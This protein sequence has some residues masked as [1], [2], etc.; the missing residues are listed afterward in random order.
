M[1]K[2]R[3]DGK[4]KYAQS[5]VAT[6]NEN[7]PKLVCIHLAEISV[8]ARL[9]KVT[10]ETMKNYLTCIRQIKNETELQ[11]QSKKPK[12][13]KISSHQLTDLGVAGNDAEVMEAWIDK[14]T[15]GM[16]NVMN[17][18]VLTYVTDW[19]ANSDG[20]QLKKVKKETLL[21]AEE[22]LKTVTAYVTSTG[23]EVFRNELTII[24]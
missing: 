23:Y 24:T 17:R 20:T 6:W 15:F 18:A 12:T 5:F 7:L 10:D 2:E 19:E 9:T 1:E 16:I 21:R 11:T 22:Q 3:C 8:R 13:W 14:D 4:D